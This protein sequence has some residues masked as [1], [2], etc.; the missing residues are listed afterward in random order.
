MSESRIVTS[1][2]GGTPVRRGSSLRT[3]TARIPL[4]RSTSDLADEAMSRRPFAS[5][6]CAMLLGADRF[7][8]SLRRQ[9]GGQIDLAGEILAALDRMRRAGHGIFEDGALERLRCRRGPASHG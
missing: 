9:L 7:G 6:T 1:P 2:C 5:G 8:L 3:F 4:A